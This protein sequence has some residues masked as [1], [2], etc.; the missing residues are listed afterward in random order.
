MK[1]YSNPEIITWARERAGMTVEV[2]AIKMK[3]APEEIEQWE[4]GEGEPSYAQLEKLAYKYLHI[5]LA[6]FFFPE[7]PKVE[8]LDT[9][10]RRLPDC[11]LRRF[12]PDTYEKFRLAQAYQLSLSELLH[13]FRFDRLIFRDI[14]PGRLSPKALAMKSREYLGISI[15]Q[16][17]RLRSCDEALKM[18]RHAVEEVG[19]FTFKDSF[20]DRFLSGF[21]ILGEDHPI[22]FINNSNSFSRQVFTLIHELGH[23]LY[24]IDGVTDVNESYLDEMA[25][26]Q[27]GLEISCN[28][29]A[30]HFLVP[31]D[32]FEDDLPYF[33]SHGHDSISEIADRYS[34]SR[35]VILRKLLI[36]GAIAEGEYEEMAAQWNQD[37]FRLKGGGK[38]GNFYRT[39]LAYLGEG[40]TRVAFDNYYSGRISRTELAKHLNM[41]SRNL[42][43]LESYMRW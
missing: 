21:C 17:S 36:H 3:R 14:V 40:F 15:K 35:E 28:S 12:S 38:H 30:G 11:E 31:D 33:R 20:D 41:N 5:P 37:Y 42:G 16:Q 6:V 39:R 7:P 8:G 25:A 1:T 34:V 2:L 23:I 18:W 22:I 32:S 27:R 19:V 9:K 4:R 10:F 13:D 24:G 26:D 29:F 43:K